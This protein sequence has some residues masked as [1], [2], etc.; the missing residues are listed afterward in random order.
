[1]NKSQRRGRRTG[2]PDTRDQILEAARSRFK[3]DGYQSVTMRSIALAAGVDVA[4]VSYYF[5]SKQGLFSAAMALPT[6]PAEVVAA[7]LAGD[8]ATLG[9]RLLRTM[10]TVW[11]D[12]DSGMP[13]RALAAAAITDEDLN[14]VIREAVTR[15]IV[16]RIAKRLGGPGARQ[17]AAALSS[18]M[19]GVIFA[20]YLLRLEPIASMSIDDVVR[21]L[22]PSLQ[23][24]TEPVRAVNAPPARPRHS[25]A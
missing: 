1:M 22:A 13:M 11:D 7:V 10:L 3:A 23:V 9:E 20:R 21:R 18:Q 25:G 16:E 17:R 19:A 15:E 4:L 6:N 5:G 8:L 14:R 24:A 12:P 2:S